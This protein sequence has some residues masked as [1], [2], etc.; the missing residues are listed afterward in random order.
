[1]F[2]VQGFLDCYVG[3]P[4]CWG[5]EL[6]RD[7]MQQAQHEARFGPSGAYY[8]MVRDSWLKQYA[9]LDFRSTSTRPPPVQSVAGQQSACQVLHI[10]FTNNYKQATIHGLRRGVQVVAVGGGALM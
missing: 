4:W 1:M 6:L 10:C 3:S 7:G 8:S 2:G 5:F 9:V